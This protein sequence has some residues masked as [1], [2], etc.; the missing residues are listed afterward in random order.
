MS[1]DDAYYWTRDVPLNEPPRPEPP[2]RRSASVGQSGLVGVLA[3][4]AA[5]G[6]LLF[7]WT[8]VRDV[9]FN[10]PYNP[11]TVVPRADLTQA[12]KT[13]IEVYND[14]RPSVVHVSTLS[15]SHDPFTLHP[16][17]KLVGQ[18]TG[19]IWDQ[20]GHIVTNYHVIENVVQNGDKAVVTLDNQKAYDA[21]VWGAYPDKDV[22]VLKIDAPRGVL[23]PL[24]LGTSKDL[25]VGQTVY[26][27]GN[28]F[29]LDQTLTSGIISALGRE[30][31]SVT[32][33]PIR[34]VIQTDAAINPGNSGGPLLDSAG[35][36]V[37]VNT[38]IASPSGAS[39]GIGFAIPIDD[40]K[41]VADQLITNRTVTR[42]GLGLH[43]VPDQV[44]RRLGVD[45][46]LFSGFSKGSPAEAAGLQRTYRNR[47]GR[48]VVGDA[49]VSCDDKAVHSVN[50]LY[51]ALEDH[52]VGDDVTLG[53][54]RNGN[55]RQVR[56]K[57][58]AVE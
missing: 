3:L 24:P 1:R 29:G 50:D 28:P 4:L 30:I 10:K 38:A 18:G 7:G 14:A 22:A 5:C 11:P 34:N 46:V 51:R 19:F 17:E 53:V 37:G 44:T 39:A 47:D 49:I 6:W 9:W 48:I 31:E 26:A 36:V 12:E 33:R 52:K 45:G 40:V 16:E 35:R 2:S 32:K 56:L 25:Q 21:T 57:L 13:T 20:Q 43:L 15:E 54:S 42:P 27:I 8:V 58:I 41:R 23:R 55:T